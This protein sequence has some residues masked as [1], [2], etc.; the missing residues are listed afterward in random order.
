VNTGFSRYWP[1]QL[2]FEEGL[3]GV[4]FYRKSVIHGPCVEGHRSDVC[5]PYHGDTAK[6]LYDEVEDK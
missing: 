1:R 5:G 3:N 2:E 4:D 6:S